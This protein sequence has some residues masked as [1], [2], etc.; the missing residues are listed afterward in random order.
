MKKWTEDDQ[1]IDGVDARTCSTLKQ[2]SHKIRD[3]ITTDN[4]IF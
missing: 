1:K 2:I 3:S 4:G